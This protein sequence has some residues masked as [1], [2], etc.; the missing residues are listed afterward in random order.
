MVCCAIQ[1][2][3]DVDVSTTTSTSTKATMTTT[4]KTTTNDRT[5]VSISGKMNSFCHGNSWHSSNAN[6]LDVCFSLPFDSSIDFHFNTII[7]HF[8]IYDFDFIYFLF[9]FFCFFLSFVFF[10]CLLL[11][12]NFFLKKKN[13]KSNTISTIYKRKNNHTKKI[14]NDT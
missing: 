14:G 3:R 8:L 12:I 11:F 1:H 7:P 13:S 6:F 9:Y 4:T 10:S 5:F 2:S